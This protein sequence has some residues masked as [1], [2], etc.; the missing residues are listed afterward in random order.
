MRLFRFSL[1]GV[2]AVL[3]LGLSSV[4]AQS[5]PKHVSTSYSLA[6]EDS[7]AAGFQAGPPASALVASKPVFSPGAAELARSH[8]TARLAA[9]DR[10]TSL[11]SP[12]SRSIHDGNRIRTGHT[13]SA[14]SGTRFTMNQK[15]A[16]P[17][18]VSNESYSSWLAMSADG[19]IAVVGAPQKNGNTGE[20][21]IYQKNGS[22]FELLTELVAPGSEPGDLF[23]YSV[24]LNSDGSIVA[25]GAPGWNDTQGA[26]YVFTR[27]GS[28]YDLTPA[29]TSSDGYDGDKFGF[30][31]AMSATGE[32]VL[33]GAP[34]N[35]PYYGDYCGGA[36][37]Y[38]SDD[39]SSSTV[40]Y[41]ENVQLWASDAY[42]GD[43]MGYSVALSG[44]GSTMAIGA[45]HTY[46]LGQSDLGTVYVGVKSGSSY[47]GTAALEPAD[48]V[49]GD[50]FGPKVAMTAD[51]AGSE[52]VV[53]S[54]YHAVNGVV[55]AGAAYVFKAAGNSY[56]Q[57]AELTAPD[58]QYND[59]LGWSVAVSA[60]GNTVLA[61]AP[62]R[63]VGGNVN[64]GTA[65]AF[66]NPGT[67][68]VATP[69]IVPPAASANGYFGWPLAI[70][71]DGTTAL[72]GAPGQNPAAGAVYEYTSQPYNPLTVTVSASGT[73]GTAPHL[74]SLAASNP[75]ISYNPSAE[76][77][78][79]SGT[80]TCST[81]ATSASPVSG[82]PYPVSSCSGLSDA[83]YDIVYDYVDS[84][85]TVNPAP[86][87]ITVDNKSVSYGGVM[88][89]FTFRGSG[90]LNWD[91]AGSFTT[92]PTCVTSAQ[93]SGRWDSSPAGSY[94]ISCSGAVDANY[95]FSYKVG[96]L[97][98]RLAGVRFAAIGPKTA[99]HGGKVTFTA[100]LLSAV[101]GQTVA[102][103]L[104]TFKL[105]KQSCSAK[106]AA[107]SGIAKCTLNKLSASK[108]KRLLVVSFAGDRV[109]PAYDFT[110]GGASATVTVK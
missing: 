44:D 51:P 31:V 71:G 84:S 74:T 106:T 25:V 8:G 91:T 62:S 110:F 70:S 6:H 16:G 17:D 23:G 21:Y 15:F 101:N 66:T 93:L 58:A 102:G 19:H 42:D 2:V 107:G 95:S 82:N 49:A 11:T 75:S 13:L 54:L 4:S 28:A 47:T 55:N 22:T 59:Q 89:A 36:A 34:L 97:T 60:D 63:T 72:L 37:Y 35:C 14:P 92:Q 29:M 50:V 104:L 38:F 43:D 87:S 5:A 9:S 40:V 65:Y 56:T 100:T 20:V 103:R 69:E 18:T 32:D 73:Y 81:T 77:A 30:S 24:A 7:L 10:A 105:L 83:G 109:G 76:A 41:T 39:P 88:P 46:A 61:D 108:G 64:A 57:S 53:G 78:N 90:F 86:L 79:V 26:V 98:V 96:T 67:G 52:I 99:K 68:F 45:P 3:G 94:H 85:Y 48:A 27:N 1:I 33:V 80:L 12:A